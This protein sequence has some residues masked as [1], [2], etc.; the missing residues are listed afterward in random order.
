MTDVKWL[1]RTFFRGVRLVLGPFMLL[2][3]AVSRPQAVER[4]AVRQAEVDR[5]CRT[6]AL[7]QF[8]TCPFCIRVRKELHRLALPVELRDARNDATHRET[9]AREGGRWKVP[10]LRIE[11]AGGARWLYESDAI[12]AYLHEQFDEQ[13][14]GTTPEVA[15]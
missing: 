14:D 8:P 15:R 7:Y 10:C 11:E 3:E 4:T 2:W 12:V 13:A 5:A 6:L 1:V 9:L